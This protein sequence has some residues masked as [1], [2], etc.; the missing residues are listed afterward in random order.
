MLEVVA[1]LGEFMSGEVEVDLRETE[2]K[3]SWRR[4]LGGAEGE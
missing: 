3:D 4:V 2:I 1:G